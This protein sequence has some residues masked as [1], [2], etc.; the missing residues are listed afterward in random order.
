VGR[1]RNKVLNLR[2]QWRFREAIERLLRT[3]VAVF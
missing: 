3:R 1:Y 2:L